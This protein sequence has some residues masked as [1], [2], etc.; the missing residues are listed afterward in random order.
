MRIDN[1]LAEIIVEVQKQLKDKYNKDLTFDEV[2]DIV[3]SHTVY[4][5]LLCCS[6]TC[7]SVTAVRTLE[8]NCCINKTVR[9]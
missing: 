4:L 9:M 6:L 2:V 1:T 3:D 7:L 8:K 5:R